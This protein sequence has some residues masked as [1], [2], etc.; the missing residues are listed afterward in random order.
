MHRVIRVLHAAAIRFS[1]D[2][3]AFLAQAIAFNALFATFP[4]LLLGIAGLAFVYGNDQGHARAVELIDTLAPGVKQFLVHNLDLVIRSRSISGII[5][6]LTLVWSGKNLFM[7]LAYALDRALGI[8]RSRPLLRSIAMSL[9]ILPFLGTILIIATALPAALSVAIKFGGFANT[10]FLSTLLG[11]GTSTFVIF[12]L[13]VFFYKYL[14]SRSTSSWF[15][16]RGALITTFGWELAQIAF[17]AYTIR[18]EWRQVYGAVSAIA[19]LMLWFY[20]MSSIFLFGAQVS[21]QWE[22]A[23]LTEDA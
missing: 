1:E 18:V 9:I 13:S 12:G 4:I 7:A 5:G 21:A 17:A 8:T 19:V 6:L 14:P 11:Y 10:V 16:I 3:C 23:T 2:G 20:Y 22:N 15:A